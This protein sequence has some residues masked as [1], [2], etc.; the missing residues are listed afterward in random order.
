M[1]LTSLQV[2]C[3]RREELQEPD[4][5]GTS[6]LQDATRED[7][8]PDLPTPLQRSHL[9]TFLEEKREDS[10]SLS[11]L[12]SIWETEKKGFQLDQKEGGPKTRKFLENSMASIQQQRDG[13]KNVQMQLIGR[14]DE[15]QGS[16]PGT[17]VWRTTERIQKRA[18]D[19][20]HD[21]WL[22]AST[23]QGRE[24]D[25]ELG[26]RH[27]W[28]QPGVLGQAWVLG[29]KK[30]STTEKPQEWTRVINV[31]MQEGGAEVPLQQEVNKV[32]VSCL[33]SSLIIS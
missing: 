6:C 30:G 25:A 10:R 31:T 27:E 33:L 29:T 23:L 18:A 17:E 28:G 5:G 3:P 26:N 16:L 13:A 9:P 32:P 20:A 8:P 1:G 21:Q 4:T 12:Q 24:E 15:G 11:C 22:L 2:R 19:W 7:G 14:T